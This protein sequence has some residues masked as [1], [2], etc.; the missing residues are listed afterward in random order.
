MDNHIEL[1]Q[2]DLDNVRGNLREVLRSEGY[3]DVNTIYEVICL[4]YMYIKIYIT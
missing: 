4:I 1:I 3:F 2:H